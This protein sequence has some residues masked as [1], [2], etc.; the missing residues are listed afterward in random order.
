[1]AKLSTEEL[2]EQ[3]KGLTLIEL[4][5]FVKAFEETFDV[6]AAAPV[7]VAA[8]G[9]AAA[10]EVVEE[11]DEF[12]VVLESAG[13]KKIQVIKVVRELTGLGLGEAK[14]LVE[15]AP[16]NVLEGA[17]KEAA[18]EAKAKLEEAGAGVKLV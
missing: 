18:E 16:K 2:L 15:E 17:K 11:K 12:D 5:E 6:S 10:A 3:F 14:A 1:M 9:P 4:S 7:A 13:D 8:A